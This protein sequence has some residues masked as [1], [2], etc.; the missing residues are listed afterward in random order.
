MRAA[1]LGL[2]ACLCAGNAL[3]ADFLR[4]STY[5]PVPAYGGGYKWQGGYVGGHVGYSEM[6]NWYREVARRPGDPALGSWREMPPAHGKAMTYGGFVGYNAQWTDIVVGFEA[7]YSHGSMRTNSSLLDPLNPGP[8]EAQLR[9]DGSARLS[10]LVTFRGRVG[11]A[12]GWVMPYAFVGLAV[13]RVDSERMVSQTQG[14]IPVPNPYPIAD[15]WAGN[16]TVGYAVGG[17]VD[18]GITRNLFL[19]GEYEYVQLKTVHGLSASVNSV[20]TGAALK[21]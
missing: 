6:S 15:R 19:R 16:W 13:A 7:N 3:A 12:W 10:D 9:W 18:I 5:E 17:G 11:Y 1:V 4:G 21:F 14:P 20:R 2:A 8:G